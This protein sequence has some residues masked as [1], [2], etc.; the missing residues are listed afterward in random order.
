[1]I[2]FA[3]TAAEISSELY[4]NIFYFKSANRKTKTCRHGLIIINNAHKPSRRLLASGRYDQRLVRIKVFGSGH[5][6]IVSSSFKSRWLL[7]FRQNGCDDVMSTSD[8]SSCR[9]Y[10]R[11][12]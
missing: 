6:S 9:L 11:T 8:S 5:S 12:D 3:G 7:N 4:V 2:F 10:R 1:M